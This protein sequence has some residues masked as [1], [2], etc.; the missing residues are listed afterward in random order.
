MVSLWSPTTAPL[1]TGAPPIYVG[2]TGPAGATGPI[3]HQG[4]TGAAG[5]AGPEGAPGD[6]GP[7]GPVSLPGVTR[8][9]YRDGSSRREWRAPHGCGA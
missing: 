7:T 1:G 2:P 4:A 5:P 6:A 8:V 9:V 3:G